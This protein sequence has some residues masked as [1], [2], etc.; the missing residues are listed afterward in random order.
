MPHVQFCDK[1]RAHLC[2]Q[3]ACPT[4]QVPAGAN[5]KS[6]VFQM[7]DEGREPSVR[8][9]FPSHLFHQRRINDSIR[10]EQERTKLAEWN[11]LYRTEDQKA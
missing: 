5:C 3:V 11:Q 6:N 1:A 7:V 10:Y 4:C 2:L 9:E 8:K